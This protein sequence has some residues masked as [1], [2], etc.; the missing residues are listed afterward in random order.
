MGLCASGK[1]SS[2]VSYKASMSPEE[3]QR[4][5][6]DVIKFRQNIKRKVNKSILNT[7]MD[8]V[9]CTIVEEPWKMKGE[10]VVGTTSTKQEARARPPVRVAR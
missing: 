9:F 8:D 1:K 10:K 7:G 3:V 2:S 4:R 6:D 5:R